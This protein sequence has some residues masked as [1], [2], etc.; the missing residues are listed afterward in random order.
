MD[1]RGAE[2]GSFSLSPPSCDRVS[3]KMFT[4]VGGRVL[5]AGSE[6]GEVDAID[7]G[8]WYSTWGKQGEGGSRARS[9][10]RSMKGRTAISEPRA[11]SDQE[12][13]KC[14]PEKPSAA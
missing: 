9:K 5:V 10:V 14:R 7:G 4:A 6:D 11:T 3:L 8:G 1:K 13:M 12:L 2:G